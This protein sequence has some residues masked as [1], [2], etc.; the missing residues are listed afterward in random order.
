M[1]SLIL[2]V[3]GLVALSA[4]VVAVIRF[5]QMSRAE[6]EAG[7]DERAR[8]PQERARDRSSAVVWGLIAL[9]VVLALPTIY[10][11]MNATG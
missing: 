3:F 2:S 7:D 10:W 8:S 1:E 11:L 6:R 4:L 9:V 5:V